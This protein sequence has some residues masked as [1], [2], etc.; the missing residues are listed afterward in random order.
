MWRYPNERYSDHVLIIELPLS[1]RDGPRELL[2]ERLVC[3]YYIS[4]IDAV[5]NN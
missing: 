1:R 5:I 3:V 4:R 2:S